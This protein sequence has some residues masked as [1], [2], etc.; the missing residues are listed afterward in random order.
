MSYGILC[1][2]VMSNEIL[3]NKPAKKSLRKVEK[4]FHGGIIFKHNEVF[5]KE[6]W[7]NELQM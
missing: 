7:R 6:T 4:I 5:R 1:Y 3:N 2:E